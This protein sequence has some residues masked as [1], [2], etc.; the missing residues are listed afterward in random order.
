MDLSKVFDII[1]HELL[2]AKGY[3]YGFIQSSLKPAF[4]YINKRGDGTKINRDLSSWEKLLV[5]FPRIYPWSSSFQYLSKH[6]AA[7]RGVL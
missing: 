5:G 1:N 7:T 2:T 3:A 4:S 6:R